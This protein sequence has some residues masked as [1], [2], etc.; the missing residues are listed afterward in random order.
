MHSRRWLMDIIRTF[1]TQLSRAN[2]KHYTEMK[3]IITPETRDTTNLHFKLRLTFPAFWALQ[4][5]LLYLTFHAEEIA[6]GAQILNIQFYIS[7]NSRI[8]RNR[9]CLS[10]HCKNGNIFWRGGFW[11]EA[12]SESVIFKLTDTVSWLIIH[13]MHVLYVYET[14][15][16]QVLDL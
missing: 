2:T 12:S 9:A 16:W 4:R 13:S 5:G 11:R 3:V 7:I 14:M 15:G 8:I 6:H 10:Q 1:L